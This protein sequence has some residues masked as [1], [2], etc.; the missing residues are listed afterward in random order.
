MVALFLS[1]LGYLVDT[2]TVYAASVLAAN[3]VLRSLFGA[4]FP[5][6]TRPMYEKL[7]IHWAAA[8]PGFLAFACM[9]FPFLFYKYGAQ[10]RARGK[11]AVEAAAMFAQIMA[12]RKAAMAGGA[13]GDAE[14]DAGFKPIDRV[15]SIEEEAPGLGSPEIYTLERTMSMEEE[16]HSPQTVPKPLPRE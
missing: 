12:A 13:T 8:L 11:Y 15:R 7:G 1:C 14:K 6:F 2:Y 9:P 10:I 5:L 16:L 4:A 3:S